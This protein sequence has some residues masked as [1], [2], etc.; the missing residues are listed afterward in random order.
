M[1]IIS[2]R[3]SEEQTAIKKERQQSRRF[4]IDIYIIIPEIAR[5]RLG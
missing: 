3:P 1:K 5:H 2:Q 4:V